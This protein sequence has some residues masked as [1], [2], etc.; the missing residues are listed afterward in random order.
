MLRAMGQIHLVRHGQASFDADDYDCLSPLGERQSRLLGDW[1]GRC[2]RQVDR[3]HRGSLRRH[4]QTADGLLEALPPALR[5]R[6]EARVDSGFDEYDHQAVLLAQRPDFADPAAMRAWL[7]GQ[8]HPRRAFQALFAQAMARWVG[9]RHDAEYAESWIAFRARCLAA[10]RRA[11]EDAGSSRTLV[12]V[13][14]GGPISAV[15]QSLLG[16]TDSAACDICFGLANSG[17]TSLFYSGERLSLAQLNNT[18][19][20]DALAD[21]QLISYR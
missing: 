20:L 8:P 18:A 3:M 9:G 5:P 4:R 17:V 16:V 12:I 6:D 19:H 13:T 2:A 15:C 21:A 11:V 14:S 7:A 10:L 1:F